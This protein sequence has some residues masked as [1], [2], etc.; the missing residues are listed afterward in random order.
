MSPGCLLDVPWVLLGVSGGGSRVS[1]GLLWR[2]GRLLVAFLA[3]LGALGRHG[4]WPGGLFM[5]LGCA[6]VSPVY[7]SGVLVSL[8]GV[9]VVSLGASWASLRVPRKRF[10]QVRRDQGHKGKGTRQFGRSGGDEAGVSMTPPP[11]EC[12]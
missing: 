5:L 1:W 11:I 8:L 7:L 4:M 10:D 6:K 2:L 12:Q 9:F 3:P